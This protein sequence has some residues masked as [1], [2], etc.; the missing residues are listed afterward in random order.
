MD[1]AWSE[2]VTASDVKE[3]LSMFAFFLF[4]LSTVIGFMSS[5]WIMLAGGNKRARKPFLEPL[6]KMVMASV[7]CMA[8]ALQL[9]L[10]ALVYWEIVVNGH[11]I[12]SV[13]LACICI[14][15]FNMCIRFDCSTRYTSL[16]V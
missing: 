16:F 14:F 15:S 2:P 1:R 11:P 9:I 6:L 3:A 7:T 4:L 8:V 13:T 5:L 12:L 10:P